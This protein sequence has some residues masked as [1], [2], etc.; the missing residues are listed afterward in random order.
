MDRKTDSAD[1]LSQLAFLTTSTETPY[2]LHYAL[3]YKD[4][5]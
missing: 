5:L 3:D 1:L 4:H 2:L